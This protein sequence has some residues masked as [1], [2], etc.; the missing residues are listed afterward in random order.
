MPEINPLRIA[1]YRL[2][3]LYTKLTT[4]MKQMMQG[5]AR[6]AK[7]DTQSIHQSPLSFSLAPTLEMAAVTLKDAH[8]EFMSMHRF[9]TKNSKI[10]NNLRLLSSAI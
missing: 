10:F 2:I 7:P 5:Y 1:K 3:N 4:T 8:Y 9:I 6:I